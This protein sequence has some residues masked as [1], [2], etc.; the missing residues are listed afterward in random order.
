MKNFKSTDT[1]FFFNTVGPIFY[2]FLKLIT[3]NTVTYKLRHVLKMSSY[4]TIM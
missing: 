2:I 4:K 1:T 3:C